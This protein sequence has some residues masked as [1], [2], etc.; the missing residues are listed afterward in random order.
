MYDKC[1]V[2]IPITELRKLQHQESNL[3][4]LTQLLTGRTE[5]HDSSCKSFF[6][7]IYFCDLVQNDN[8]QLSLQGKD[9]SWNTVTQCWY[10]GKW[11]TFLNYL[12][13]YPIPAGFPQVH[14]KCV[15][16]NWQRNCLSVCFKSL[17]PVPQVW[18]R[19]LKCQLYNFVLS[20]LQSL[21][22]SPLGQFIVQCEVMNSYSVP[23]ENQQVLLSIAL[24]T[25]VMYTAP[26]SG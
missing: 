20:S 22:A 18:G 10:W 8:K 17:I 5:E 1:S 13:G 2:T 24:Q 11:Y 14:A 15:T 12:Q 3:T 16:C 9:M 7:S 21:P 23:G 19:C 4:Q 26:L 25:I 6:A